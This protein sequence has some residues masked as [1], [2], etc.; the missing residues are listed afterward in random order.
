MTAVWDNL[1]V[2]GDWEE[3]SRLAAELIVAELREKPHLILC[4]A[5][6]A[7]PTATYRHLTNAFRESPRLFEKMR[8]LALDEWGGVDSPSS[9]RGYLQTHL[10]EPLQI[11]PDRFVCFQADAGRPGDECAR[12]QAWLDQHGPIDCC[13]LGLGVNG[14]I[15]LNEPGP[16]LQPR[17]HP[18]ALAQTTLQHSMLQSAKR[19]PAFGYTLGMADL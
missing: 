7:S 4:A 18:A 19:P 10:V 8:I 12:V 11:A 14:H 16:A 9:C 2:G 3:L 6:G 13:V 17:I 15:G 1:H 5:T